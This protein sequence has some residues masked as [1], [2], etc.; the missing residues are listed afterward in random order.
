MQEV[1]FNSATLFDAL[2]AQSKVIRERVQSVAETVLRTRS[3]TEL[4]D[5]LASDLQI[6]PLELDEAGRTMR[7]EEI[8]V[9]VSRDPMRAIFNRDGPVLIPGIRATF[10]TPFTGDHQLWRLQ[11]STFN[12]S[13]PRGSIRA[14]HD[15]QSGNL[16]ISIE[17]PTDQP[18]EQ[19][20]QRLQEIDQNIKFFIGNQRKDLAGYDGQLRR[21]IASAI[22]DRRSRLVKH[23]GLADLLGIPEA[24]DSGPKSAPQPARPARHSSNMAKPTADAQSWDVFISHASEDKDSFARPLAEA[25]EAAG[26]SVWFDESTLTIGDSLRRSIDKGL[27]RSRYGIVIVS[28]AFL[29]KDW[30]QREL[31][32]LVAKEDDG[33][34]VV[35]PVWHNITVSEVRRHSPTLADRLAIS[36][37]KGVSTVVGELLRVVR[38]VNK[39]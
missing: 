25:L 17:Q 38:S 30:P 32:G 12:L 34:K 16:E 4:I 21:E 29:S 28:E 23:D 8:R 7:Q 1:L 13:P 10:I 39:V 31:D 37:S 35:L 9:D 36:S 3:D 19:I 6:T 20:K 5:D 22:S 26:V 27:A 2:H 33:G 11:P 18:L 24:V 15:G 14:S